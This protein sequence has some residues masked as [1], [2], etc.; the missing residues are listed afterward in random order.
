V[1]T[2]DVVHAS[3]GAKLLKPIALIIT[4]TFFK[5]M[6]VLEGRNFSPLGPLPF[7]TDVARVNFVRYVG[8]SVKC[9][10]L[11]SSVQANSAQLGASGCLYVVF[12]LVRVSNVVGGAY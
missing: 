2:L 4:I 7:E 10:C 12:C 8:V 6:C 1:V 3:Q 5:V 11:C 9:D